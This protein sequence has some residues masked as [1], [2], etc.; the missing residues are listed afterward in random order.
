MKIMMGM[1]HS[2]ISKKISLLIILC[3]TLF[4][5]NASYIF[6]PMDES[7][8][9]HLKAYG[10]AYFSIDQGIKV[11]WL[12]NYQ[13][14]SFM[15]KYNE[16]I[17]NECSVRGVSFNIIADVQSTQILRSISSPE[18]NQD[19]VRLEKA[20]KIA[21]YSPSNKQPWDDAVTMALIYAEIPYEVIY[22][23]EV[24]SNLLPLY[25]WLH[26]HHEDFTGQYGKF[27]ASYKNAS[28]YKEQKIEYERLANKLGYNKVSQEKLA[29]AKKIKEY[30]Y[31]GGFLFAMCSATDS[32]DIALSA[33]G[34]DI[35]AQMFDGDGMD[36][37]AQD[38]LDFS[39]T[40]AFKDFSI[41][42]YCLPVKR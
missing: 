29:V 8:S 14:G 5:A 21:I 4:T 6:I 20:P 38:K 16:K 39:K 37:S 19:V 13:G 17:E 27:Y 23:E 36:P 15:I 11:D 31:G 2:R 34:T 42:Y 26:L 9:N 25:D 33:E 30:I 35:C 24:L 41:V 3:S 32:Y 22:D 7:Q 40:L 12:L 10:I 1:N 28:W 18:V